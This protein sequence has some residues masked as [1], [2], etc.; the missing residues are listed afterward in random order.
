MSL[1]SDCD[2][3]IDAVETILHRDGVR[4][5]TERLL[6]VAERHR[7]GQSIERMRRKS[8]Y[9]TVI[10]LQG[11]GKTSLLNSLLFARRTLPIGEGTTT[12][13][14]CFVREARNDQPHCDVRLKG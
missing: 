12:N 14:I 2:S 1:V 3:I 4:A 5:A 8:A 7:I 9:V 13:V 10:G 11:S 6:A